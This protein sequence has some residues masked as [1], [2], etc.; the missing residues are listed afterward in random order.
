MNVSLTSDLPTPL[1]PTAGSAQPTTKPEATV[2]GEDPRTTVPTTQ[3]T[4]VTVAVVDNSTEVTT[5]SIKT[6]PTTKHPNQFGAFTS[7]DDDEVLTTGML[8]N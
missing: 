3:A 2:T 5:N 6:T 7:G 8:L 1:T 4:T